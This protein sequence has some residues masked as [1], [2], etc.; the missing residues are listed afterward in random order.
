MD[1]IDI[2]GAKGNPLDGTC[3]ELTGSVSIFFDCK[4]CFTLVFSE[5]DCFSSGG[6]SYAFGGEDNLQTSGFDLSPIRPPELLFDLLLLTSDLEVFSSI[7]EG[8]V[9]TRGRYS[10]GRRRSLLLDLE[11]ASAVLELIARLGGCG[12]N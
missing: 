9:G 2:A 8:F 12:L 1:T 10:D 3:K 4:V 6:N 5:K 11:S 7:C